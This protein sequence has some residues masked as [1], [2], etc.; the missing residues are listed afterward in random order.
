MRRFGTA[1]IGEKANYSR[2]GRVAISN[3]AKHVEG[4]GG[5]G[6]PIEPKKQTSLVLDHVAA[7]QALSQTLRGVE[8]RGLWRWILASASRRHRTPLP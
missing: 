6:R 1:A 7:L 8:R 5:V 4:A 3:R 2:G